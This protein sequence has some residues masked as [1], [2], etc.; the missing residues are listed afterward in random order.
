MN[1]P[2][3]V[4]IQT[5]LAKAAGDVMRA[6]SAVTTRQEAAIKTLAKFSQRHF[7]RQKK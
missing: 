3:I 5:R 2:P 7:N 1:Y 6:P 4:V